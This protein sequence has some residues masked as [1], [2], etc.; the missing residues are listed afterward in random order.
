MDVKAVLKLHLL[1]FSSRWEGKDDKEVGRCTET[2]VIHVTVDPKFFRPTEV[3]SESSLC[4]CVVDL[5]QRNSLESQTVMKGLE[6][7]VVTNGRYLIT[8]LL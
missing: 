7:K 4:G 5:W 3:V 8:L 6:L 2:G 1:L